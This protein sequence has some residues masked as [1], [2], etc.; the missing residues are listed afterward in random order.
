MAPRKRLQIT[1]MR[2][3]HGMRQK[4][5]RKH[6]LVRRST[7]PK[8]EREVGR[9]RTCFVFRLGRSEPVSAGLRGQALLW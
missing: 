8:A 2:S 9:L 6:R 7:R 4:H 1:A 5:A 3:V